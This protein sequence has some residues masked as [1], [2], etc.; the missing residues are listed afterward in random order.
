MLR[1]VVYLK[2]ND[3]YVYVYVYIYIKYLLKLN[4]EI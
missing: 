3:V 1:C 2:L 4:F